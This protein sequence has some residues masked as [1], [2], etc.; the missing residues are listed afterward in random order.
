MYLL[1]RIQKRTPTNHLCA[2]IMISHLSSNHDILLDQLPEEPI[3]KICNNLSLPS[4]FP[5]KSLYLYRI[6]R[7]SIVYSMFYSRSKSAENG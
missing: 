6:I 2:K 4:W 7:Y 1:I 3:R 5:F